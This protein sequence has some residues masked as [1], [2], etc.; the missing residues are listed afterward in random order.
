LVRN[1]VRPF[2]RASIAD[3]AAELQMDMDSAG[4]VDFVEGTFIAVGAMS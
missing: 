3:V 2:A 1:A 4:S